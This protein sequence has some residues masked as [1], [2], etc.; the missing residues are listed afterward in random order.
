MHERRRRRAWPDDAEPR[1]TDIRIDMA[2]Y[3]ARYGIGSSSDPVGEGGETTPWGPLADAT[4]GRARLL[5]AVATLGLE[6][7]AVDPDGT[8]EVEFEATDAFTTPR[9]DVLEGYL[10][11]MLH[12]VVGP[13]V[14]ATLE[15]GQFIVT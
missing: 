6:V 15:P 13:A 1:G 14:I 8:I 9:G 12:D 2:W 7:V 11:A 5:P 10:A 3:Q 4:D